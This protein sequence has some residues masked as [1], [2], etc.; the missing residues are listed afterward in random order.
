[1]GICL[2]VPAVGRKRPSKATEN[3][4]DMLVLRVCFSPTRVVL[5]RGVLMFGLSV[6]KGLACARAEKRSAHPSV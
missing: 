5:S 3:K 2:V 4:L 6:K 1:M